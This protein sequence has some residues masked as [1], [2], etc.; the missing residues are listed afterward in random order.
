MKKFAYLSDVAFSF[1]ISGVCTLVLFRYLGVSLPLSLLL[2]ALCGG[3]TA[4]AVAAALSARRKNLY[5]KKSDENLRDKL[6][7]HL[8][9][10]SDEEK[11][12][13]FQGLLSTAEEPINRFGKLRL[14][15]RAEFFFI[16]FSPSPLSADEIPNLA[17][18]K[19]GKKK[20][21]LCGQI[22]EAALSLCQRLSIEVRTGE[23]TYKRFKERNALPKTYLGEGVPPP[24]RKM[25]VCF[26]KRNAK[27]FLSSGALILLLS[28]LTPFYY[29]YLLFGGGLL[30]TALFIRIFGYAE[31]T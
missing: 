16:K 26:S 24:K 22:E 20:I 10:L 13:I 18:L 27:R 4:L 8:A 19:T 12:T 1:F 6:L 3:L 23:W 28:R 25:K 2:A 29:Y 15:N 21:L 5:L 31:N 11:T 30:L 9:L 14:F 17:R 7:L